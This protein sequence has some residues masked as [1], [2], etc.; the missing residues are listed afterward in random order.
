M[1]PIRKRFALRLFAL[2]YRGHQINSTCR[3]F[4]K[5]QR[6]FEK[7]FKSALEPLI[8]NETVAARLWDFGDTPLRSTL[9]ERYRPVASWLGA[10][11]VNEMPGLIE[12]LAQ[13][14][15][16]SQANRVFYA[17]CV[18]RMFTLVSGMPTCLIPRM[19]TAEM[20]PCHLRR[21]CY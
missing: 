7:R 20:C 13:V 3:D 21:W 18:G 9:N 2:G 19:E 5:N 17:R 8:E 4:K 12:P 15:A 14:L 6:G 11:L 16:E 10:Q 1:F